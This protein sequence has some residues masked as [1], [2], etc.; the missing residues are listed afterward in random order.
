MLSKFPLLLETQ[1]DEVLG[2]EQFTRIVLATKTI[3]YSVGDIPYFI[4]VEG[5][6]NIYPTIFLLWKCPNILRSFIIHA[7][8]SEYVMKVS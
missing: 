5:R 3:I 6:N 1:L 4:D 7:P 8:V 2:K